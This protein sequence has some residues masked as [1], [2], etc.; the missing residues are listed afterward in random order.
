M[1]AAVRGPFWRPQVRCGK[2][3]DRIQDLRTSAA[4]HCMNCAWTGGS[5]RVQANSS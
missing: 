4:R 3:R 5:R 2:W 1:L